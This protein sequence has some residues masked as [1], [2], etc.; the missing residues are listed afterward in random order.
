ME[1]LRDCLAKEYEKVLPKS[2][3]GKAFCYLAARF[4]KISEYLQN[5]RLEIDN[6]LIENS[7][8]PVALGR[9]NYLFAGSHAGA[10]RAAIIYSLLGSCKLQGINPYE[11]LPGVLQRLPEQPMNR[12]AELLPPYWKSASITLDTRLTPLKEG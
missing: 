7:I 9:K 5:G 3:I 10:Q 6:N 12:L 8:R 2:M 11:Y 4:H 1:E